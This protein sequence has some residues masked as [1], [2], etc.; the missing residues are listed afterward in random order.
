MKKLL[1]L[2]VVSIILALGLLLPLTGLV[3]A[4]GKTKVGDYALEIGFHNEPAYV[5][6]PNSLDLFVTNEKTGKAVNGLEST[7]KAEIIF[8]ASKKSVT[9]SP[10]D[11]VD[12]GYTAAVIP[13]VVGDY[14]WHISGAIEGTPVDVTMTSSPDT[15][16]SVTAKTNDL[17]PAASSDVSSQPSQVALIVSIFGIALGLAG[18]VV[19]T[20]ALLAT[21]RH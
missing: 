21:R 14:T 2:S 1:S 13:T 7:L 3:L 9:L 16:V 5:N 4:H 20:V 12:G 10:Q 8:G 15:F 17:F 18:V 6:E 19:G 11:G